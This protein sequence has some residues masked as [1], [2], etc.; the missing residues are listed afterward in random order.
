MN[1]QPMT[2]VRPVLVELGAFAELTPDHQPGR[3]HRQPVGRLV[4]L[5]ATVAD[6]ARS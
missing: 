1:E 4:A 6:P 3:L 5:S 2:Y